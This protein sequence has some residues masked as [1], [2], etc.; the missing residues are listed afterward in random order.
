ME[1]IRQHWLRA[2]L[3]SV[4]SMFLRSRI[5]LAMTLLVVLVPADM[6]AAEVTY[7]PP[8]PIEV[9]E[10]AYPVNSVATGAVVVIVVVERDGQ[11]S[12]AKVVKSVKSLDEASVYA[13]KQWRFE[14][15]QLDGQP[16]RSKASISFVYNRG[17]FPPQ[18]PKK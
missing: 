3:A 8:V 18:E 12:E 9:T 7:T 6:E 17:L 15:A 1:R 11:V 16:I 13:A 5:C 14:P 2:G 10:A 4:I